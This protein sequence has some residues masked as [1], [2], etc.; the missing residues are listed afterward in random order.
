M[1]KERQR[2]DEKKKIVKP[3]LYSQPNEFAQN[4]ILQLVATK[5]DYP[6]IKIVFCTQ[7]FRLFD[8]KKGTRSVGQKCVS[9]SLGDL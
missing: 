6:E 8:P 1:R 3:R 4:V 5:F 7:N 2:R 9:L